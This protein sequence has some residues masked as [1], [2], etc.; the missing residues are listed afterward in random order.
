[1]LDAVRIDEDLLDAD[2][3]TAEDKVAE[4]CKNY[5][6]S[7]AGKA[8]QEKLKRKLD[9]LDKIEE[10]NEREF[11]KLKKTAPRENV[12]KLLSNDLTTRILQYIFTSEMNHVMLVNK[13]LYKAYSSDAIWKG[14]FDFFGNYFSKEDE[15]RKFVAD[16]KSIAPEQVSYYEMYQSVITDHCVLCGV[17]CKTYNAFA[18]SNICDKC[19]VYEKLII[20]SQLATNYSFDDEQISELLP[21]EL[22]KPSKYRPPSIW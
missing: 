11:K 1:M 21:N 19:V 14:K 7:K 20:K 17:P 6:N 18:K 9:K 22:R 10:E 2:K 12:F 5:S 8:K 16:K 15:I 3:K 13:Q 4:W